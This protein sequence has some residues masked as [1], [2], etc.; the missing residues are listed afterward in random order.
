[1]WEGG[2]MCDS[3]SMRCA[4]KQSQKCAWNEVCVCVCVCGASPLD[5]FGV[6]VY[7]SSVLLSDSSPADPSGSFFMNHTMH[8]NFPQQLLS[9]RGQPWCNGLPSRITCSTHVVSY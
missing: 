8:S 1:M 2:R 6:L 5:R 4:H 9:M 3:T 7:S